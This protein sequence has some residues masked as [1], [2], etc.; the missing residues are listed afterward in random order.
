MRDI[1]AGHR[2]CFD[3]ELCAIS[4]FIVAGE[5]LRLQELVEAGGIANAACAA[6]TPDG[7]AVRWWKEAEALLEV[8]DDEAA[9]EADGNWACSDR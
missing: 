4:T 7:L 3:I 5:I 2:G 9:S 6:A 1:T 8:G